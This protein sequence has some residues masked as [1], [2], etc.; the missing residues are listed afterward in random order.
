MAD[1][2]SVFQWSGTQLT[3]RW[4]EPSDRAISAWLQH[5]NKPFC[6]SWSSYRYLC[7]ALMKEIFTKCNKARRMNVVGHGDQNREACWDSQFHLKCR[8]VNHRVT[9]GLNKQCSLKRVFLFHLTEATLFNHLPFLKMDIL[10][11]AEMKVSSQVACH[12]LPTD[13][14]VWIHSRF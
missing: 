13:T 11:C 1:S 7:T 5:S 14:Q 9:R 10:V 12:A 4:K 8:Q 2:I 3:G 6:A